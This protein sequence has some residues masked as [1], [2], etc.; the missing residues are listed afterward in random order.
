MSQ[1]I[2]RLAFWT[3][4]LTTVWLSLITAA[5][6]PTALHFWDKAQHALGFAGLAYLGMMA[7]PGQILKVLLGLMLLGVGIECAQWMT[8]WRQ[9]DWQDW[10]ADCFG[11][12]IGAPAWC[13]MNRRFKF[14]TK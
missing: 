13:L 1:L 12:A 7:Y 3:L 2:W 9:G 8:S 10:V 14:R 6:I 4:V 11:L 5:L